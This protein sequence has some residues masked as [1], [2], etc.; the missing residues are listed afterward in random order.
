MMLKKKVFFVYTASLSAPV[1][2]N[3]NHT[4]KHKMFRYVVEQD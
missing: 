3:K 2:L 4:Q 1:V